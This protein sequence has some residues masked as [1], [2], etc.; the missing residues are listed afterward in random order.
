MAIRGGAVPHAQ[1]VLKLPHKAQA[2]IKWT[3]D[4]PMTVHLEGYDLSA[5]VRP[6]QPE[7]MQFR[8]FATGRFAVH[9]H[10]GEQRGAPSTHSHGRRVLLWLEVHPK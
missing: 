7:F 3:T 8:A 1:R 9:A 2:R 10:E 4:R 6:H 5:T